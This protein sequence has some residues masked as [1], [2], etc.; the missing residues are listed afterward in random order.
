MKSQMHMKKSVL[1][2]FSLLVSTYFSSCELVDFEKGAGHPKKSG[3]TITKINKVME[4]FVTTEG[5]KDQ[6]GHR[7][8]YVSPSSK[9]NFVFKNYNNP[10]LVEL[11]RDV[12]IHVFSSWDYEYYPVYSNTKFYI[13]QGV[14]IDRHDFQGYRDGV[15]DI[16]G[17][18]LFM[19]LE[20]EEGWKILN[21]SSTIVNPD[22]ETDYSGSI[23]STSPSTALEAFQ[24]GFNE[25]DSALF[26]SAFTNVNASCVRFRDKFLEDYSNELHSS[27]A[28]YSSLPEGMDGL[29][30]ELTRLKID[31]HDQLTA[32]ATSE[33]NITKDGYPIEKGKVLATLIA[34]PEQGWKISSM[35]LSISAQVKALQ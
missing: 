6:E 28:F 11:E 19:Y 34:T 24:T 23:I 21:I 13:E 17:N 4:E 9:L 8:L 1:F 18:D 35:A 15:K 30:L 14:V 33:Y 2:L 25:R 31:T 12:W 27:Q 32:V 29:K 16:F 20:T 7:A 3:S 26:K 22:D 10:F 5:N